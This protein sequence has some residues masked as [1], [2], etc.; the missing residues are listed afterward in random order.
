MADTRLPLDLSG[1]ATQAMRAFTFGG[2]RYEPGDRFPWRQLSC[3][4]RK[5]QQLHDNRFITSGDQVVEPVVEAEETP[6][7]TRKAPVRRTKKAD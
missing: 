2:R 5:A 7:P 1:K 6:K 4:V 3:S